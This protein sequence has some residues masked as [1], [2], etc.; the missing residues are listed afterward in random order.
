MENCKKRPADEV[1]R[2][3]KHLKPLKFDETWHNHP[4]C[5]A[6]RV[7]FVLCH[8]FTLHSTLAVVSVPTNL[9]QNILIPCFDLGMEKFECA[10]GSHKAQLLLEL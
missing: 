3:S 1:K 9:K 6:F 4:N 8:P 2:R 10:D 5:L 7:F